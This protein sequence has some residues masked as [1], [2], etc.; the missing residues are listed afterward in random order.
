MLELLAADPELTPGD[1]GAKQEHHPAQAL[2]NEL[3]LVVLRLDGIRGV[4]ERAAR[5][6]VGGQHDDRHGQDD[7]CGDSEQQPHKLMV[8]N[9]KPGPLIHRRIVA[10][11]LNPNQDQDGSPG[12]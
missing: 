2:Q 5:R 3:P 9:T 4:S 8:H 10:P 12:P 1:I 6:E 11:P 7:Q